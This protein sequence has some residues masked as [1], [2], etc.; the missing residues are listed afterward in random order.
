MKEAP[1]FAR[2]Y[3]FFSWLLDRMA[4]GRTFPFL[5]NTVLKTGAALIEDLTLALQGFDTHER[6]YRADEALA[7]LRLYLRLAEEKR[8]LNEDQYLFAMETM[9]EMGKQ[10]GGW[11]K[12]LR[13]QR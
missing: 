13:D 2:G 7:L 10:L 1:L 8:V 11:L 12:N 9:E 4:K 5:R 3:T 6:A